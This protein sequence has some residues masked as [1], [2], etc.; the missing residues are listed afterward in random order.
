MDT[1]TR[2]LNSFVT[3]NLDFLDLN[4]KVEFMGKSA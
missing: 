3:V 2:E 1:N 4:Y